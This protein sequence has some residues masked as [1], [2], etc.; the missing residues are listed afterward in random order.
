MRAVLC[1]AWGTPD[2]LVVE[3][4]AEPPMTE[5]GAR[6][7]VMAA[8]INFAD[9]LAIQGKYQVKAPLPFSPGLE[10]AGEV[11]EVAPGVSGLRP[12]DRVAFNDEYGAWAEQVVLPASQ[13][14]TIPAGMDWVTAGGF[15]VVY[16]TSYTGL[17]DRGGLKAGDWLMVHGAAG[18]VGLTAVEIGKKVGATVIATAGSDEK[19]ALARS[20]GADFTVNSSDDVR[21]R[22]K[23]ITGGRGCDVIYDPVGGDLFDASIRCL[24]WG[25]RIIVIGFASGRIP[26]APANLLLVKH[27]GVLGHYLGSYRAHALPALT[28][29][30]RQLFAWYQEGSLRPHVSHTFPMTGVAE[31][32]RTLLARKSTGK[33]VLDLAA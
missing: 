17:I 12:G 19:L 13:V 10:G 15:P 23:E 21:A 18:G 6:I 5:G 30:Y 27:A 33:V 29:A 22:V 31:A 9:T 3:E 8:G 7:R 20:Y 24:A 2:D 1:K 25:G 11:I 28:A 16:S 26:Q 4:V 14:W 32:L